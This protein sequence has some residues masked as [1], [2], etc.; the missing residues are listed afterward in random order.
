MPFADC[1]NHAN[2]A[3]TY[4]F[5]AGGNG[6]FRLFPSR[7]T[8]F[9]QGA[10]AFNS[11]GRRPNFQLL[12]DY[13][14]A[15]ED[16]EWD[17][18]DVEMPKERPTGRRVRFAT[19]ASRVVRIDRQTTLDELF[20]PDLLLATALPTTGSPAVSPPPPPSSTVPLPS[21]NNSE[22][23]S[24]A[25]AIPLSK[26]LEWIRGALVGALDELGGERAGGQDE[27]L[28]R[29][30]PEIP[31][32][33]RAAIIHRTSRRRLLLRMLTQLDTKLASCRDGDEAVKDTAAETNAVDEASVVELTMEKLAIS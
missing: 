1:L 25:D 26:A 19:R 21:N 17:F 14:F 28:L 33:L 27:L 32:R 23:S 3:I 11:Y 16:N 29:T 20:P 6:C 12:L 9:A 2:V 24:E 13:G 18:I 5:D 10:E 22:D 31:Y 7:D 8:A 15:L 30:Q 4:D